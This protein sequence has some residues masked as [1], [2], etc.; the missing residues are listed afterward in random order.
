MH[1]GRF[2]WDV[3]KNSFNERTIK[4]WKRAVVEPPFLGEF[5]SL[6][7]VALGD[8]VKWWLWQCWGTLG[9]EGF[10]Y[11]N[12]SMILRAGRRTGCTSVS[13]LNPNM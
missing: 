5:E 1:Q 11:L 9:L 2:R 3:R 8:M 7:G 4:H 13:M 12:D 10:S 6:V